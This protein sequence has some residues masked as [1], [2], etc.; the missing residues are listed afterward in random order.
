MLPGEAFEEGTGRVRP[1]TATVGLIFDVKDHSRPKVE[2]ALARLEAEGEPGALVE[3][4]RLGPSDR[5]DRQSARLRRPSRRFEARK[6]GGIVPAQSGA[7]RIVPF[8][9]GAA[10]Q[11]GE[12]VACP[13]GLG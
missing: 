7:A 10:R 9:G 6:E 5:F 4:L 3:A 1:A 11:N 8:P 13:Q 12:A 2:P